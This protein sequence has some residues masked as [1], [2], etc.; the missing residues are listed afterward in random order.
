MFTVAAGA[1]ICA[2]P[3]APMEVM[4]HEGIAGFYSILLGLLLILMGLTFWFA[5]HFRSLAGIVAVILAAACLVLSNLGGFF[6]GTV[7]AII[8]GSM[9]FGWQPHPHRQDD[10]AAPG[11]PPGEGGAPRAEDGATPRSAP[12]ARSTHPQ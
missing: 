1:E 12:P 5:P 6:L 8:G 3:L 2:I 10:A 4:L 7:V 11:E 9:G